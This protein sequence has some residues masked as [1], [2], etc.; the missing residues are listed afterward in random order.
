M[1]KFLPNLSA[2]KTGGA[3]IFSSDAEG[4]HLEIPAGPAGVYRLAQLDDYSTLPR[5]HFPWQPPLTISLQARASASSLPGTWG[6]GLWNDPF[7]FS[8][9]MGGGTRRFPALPNAAWFFFASSPNYL[10]LRDDLPAA[11]SLAATFRAPQLPAL[12]LAPG[13][14]ALPLLS[15]RPLARLFRRLARQLI[16]Q[17]AASLPVDASVWHSYCIEWHQELVR[18]TVDGQSVLEASAPPLA[19]LGLVLWIDNQY[20]ALPPDGDISFGS[21]PNPGPAW[22]QIRN[23]TIT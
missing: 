17:S 11:G 9:G 8:L 2:T 6:F 3:Q 4:W 21:L 10:S 20:A 5:N 15:I 7:S 12:L 19:P 18:F 23:L 13:A 22:I 14:L 16:L 1:D